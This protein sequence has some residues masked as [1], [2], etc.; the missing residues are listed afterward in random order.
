[1]MTQAPGL[2]AH[3][4]I[5]STQAL[6]VEG[7]TPNIAEQERERLCKTTAFRMAASSLRISTCCR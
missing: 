2:G 3:G 1:M 7:L 6:P 5:I 4:S